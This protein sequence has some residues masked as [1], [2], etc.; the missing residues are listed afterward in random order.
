ME[1]PVC[2]GE[3]MPEDFVRGVKIKALNYAFSVAAR[4]KIIGWRRLYSVV[5][6][7]GERWNR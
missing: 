5:W 1:T 6:P 3:N 7:R 2:S 4:L